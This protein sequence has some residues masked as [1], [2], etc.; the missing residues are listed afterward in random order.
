MI[1]TLRRLA[2]TGVSRRLFVL[3][4]L[5][6]FLPL[7]AIAL[8]SLAQVR[9]LL[10]QQGE[11]RLAAVAKSYGMAL[12]ERLLVAADVG[13]SVA[14]K[15]DVALPPD[16]LAL[17]TF[18]SLSMVTG[19]K[20][21]AL[22]GTPQ[23]PSLSPEVFSRVAAG[24]PAVF[25]SIA[26]GKPRIFLAAP[27]S[28]SAKGFVVG[29]LRPQYLW[30]PD[31]ELP[32]ATE[33]CVLEDDSGAP[34]H[35]PSPID[36]KAL[37]SMVASASSAIGTATWTRGDQ[38]IRS[39][40]W[41]QFMVAG[42]GTP[43]WIVVA[44]QPEGYQ[45]ARVLEFRRIYIPVVALALALVT[46][47]TIRQSRNIVVPVRQLVERARGVANNDFA[48][49]LHLKRSDEFGELGMAFDQMSYRLGRQFASLKA[50]S[51][52]DQLILATQDTSQVIRMIL[53]RVSDVVRADFVSLTIFDHDN[54]DRSK[55]YFRP[56]DSQDT[57]DMDRHAIS[58]ADRAALEG[59]A[60][61]RWVPL[62]PPA[63]APSYLAHLQAHGMLG[64]HVQPIAWRGEVCGALALG[65]RKESSPTDEERQQVRELADRVAV[66]VSS[67]WRDEKLYQ[68]AHFDPLTGLPN[69]LLFIDRLATEIARSQREKLS[70]A[71]LFIDLDNFKI[72]NDSFGHPVGDEVLC[73]A[74][75][76][77]AQCTR[78]T[79]TVSRL[80]GDEFTVLL[81]RLGHPREALQIAEEMVASLSREFSLGTEQCFLSASI[82]IASYPVDGTSAEGLLK[83]A[84]TA[85]YRAKSGGRSQVVFFEERMNVEA[86][87][88]L[89]LDRDLRVAIEHG[90]LVLHYQPQLDLRTGAIRGAE[91]LIR[92]QHPTQGLVLPAR[93][94][95][96]AE[97]SGFIEQIGRW[98][99]QQACAQM[100]A[101]RLSGLPIDRV[102]V[103][104][105]P[106][107]FGKRTIIEYIRQCTEEAGLPASCLDIEI[108]E[109]LLL[110]RGE[111]VEGM[112]QEL[113]AMGHAISLD[114][115][116]TGF[117]SMAYLKR[118]A[119]QIIKIDR[120]F[121]DG[122]ERSP[123]SEAIVN[124]IIAMSHAL[125]KSV[126][127]EGVE[128]D[129]QLAL[130]RK[131][132]CDEI[133]G[134]LVSKPLPAAEFAELLRSRARIAASA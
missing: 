75:R 18:S 36:E 129:E 92:W 113:A 48:T 117:S 6:A 78:V 107:Q 72:V 115:F 127:A 118:F 12:F 93:F 89:T 84:D 52:I 119:V 40:R 90:E 80:G 15:L 114:D 43:D 32:T 106:R 87:A 57:M 76:R 68:Q 27:V 38:N 17:R 96:V 125:G 100:K 19:E 59:D 64:A 116:G 108:T 103:N 81:T 8:L 31:D 67:A 104:F 45:L 14:Y 121:I 66:A 65:F 13:A 105:S 71:V 29:E 56:P 70:F 134:Y 61:S 23:V 37:R 128:T 58:A 39:L 74:T 101:W 16:A 82:G 3:F 49:R 1:G 120:V 25:V 73:E 86:V 122:F 50:L 79:D 124:A 109:R 35:C 85:M 11:Q 126:I 9:S 2:V 46:W 20:T 60:A 88:R 22:I 21:L 47:L 95:P 55:T 132:D 28:P 110:D 30:G 62:S 7:A 123:D 42:F 94:I 83:N 44:S 26:R 130:L 4:I 77:I 91:A 33:F 51:E 97:D 69:R 24:K 53:H 99:L 98:T 102:S 112:L 111:A 133:Q 41:S 10:L 5:S 54:P 34:L 131:L 63:A